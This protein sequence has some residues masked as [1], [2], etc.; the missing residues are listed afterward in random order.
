MDVT[1]EVIRDNVKDTNIEAG[2]IVSITLA[3]NSL[4]K[5]NTLNRITVTGI[6]SDSLADIREAFT[7]PLIE[8]QN[9]LRSNVVRNSEWKFNIRKMI[10]N[11]LAITQEL[12]NYGY[13]SMS[14]EKCKDYLGKRTIVSVTNISADIL[15]YATDGDVK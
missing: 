12:S 1:F 15:R 13:V 14:W 2:E 4:H 5:H 9:D 6:P 8:T 3:S 7:G 11:D 10:Q